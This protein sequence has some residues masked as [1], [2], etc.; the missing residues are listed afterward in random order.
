MSQA[1]QHVR[2]H[3]AC[4][5]RDEILAHHGDVGAYLYHSGRCAIAHA[6]DQ[7]SVVNPDD[8]QDH[9]RLAA[10]LPLIKALAEHAIEV[11]FGVKSAR[12]VRDEHLYE[13]E[14]FRELLSEDVLAD[15]KAGKDVDA[16]RFKIPDRLALRLGGVA[17]FS[18]FEDLHA[19]IAKATSGVAQ[20][21]LAREDNLFEGVVILNFRDERLYFDAL[22]HVVL[23]DDGTTQ[24]T[25][26]ILDFLA[27][28]RRWMVLT[29]A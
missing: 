28:Q 27:F 29:R 11:E 1:A 19:T 3:K 8:P 20:L 21:H 12:T 7:S 16:S 17:P 25:D 6:H 24:A 2:D 14:G 23:R 15:L 22:E 5:R 18:S 26:V 13:L 9:I 10:D 4:E